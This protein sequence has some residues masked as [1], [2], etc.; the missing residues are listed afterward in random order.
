MNFKDQ[1]DFGTGLEELLKIK[2]RDNQLEISE[3]EVLAELDILEK[4]QEKIYNE[5]LKR[6]S[7]EAKSFHN[8][9]NIQSQ[10]IRY[11]TI[12][13]LFQNETEGF[14]IESI[15]PKEYMKKFKEVKN[16]FKRFLEED[17]LLKQGLVKTAETTRTFVNLL[18]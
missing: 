4:D 15:D 3:K 8:F 13:T 7:D 14:S 12:L 5:L 18:R 16:F 17:S 1:G 11:N 9:N 6:L 10:R 2:E